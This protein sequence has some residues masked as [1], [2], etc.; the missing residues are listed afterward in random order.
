[1]HFRLFSGGNDYLTYLEYIAVNNTSRVFRKA[2]NNHLFMRFVQLFLVL[3]SSPQLTIPHPK[4]CL[5]DRFVLSYQDKDGDIFL[6]KYA[7]GH[8]AKRAA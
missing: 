6:E 4:D 8:A 2:S 7:V 5:A 3:L 1:M